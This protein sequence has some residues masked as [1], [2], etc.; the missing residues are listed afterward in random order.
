MIKTIFTMVP[1]IVVLFSLA[2]AG[3][4][5]DKDRQPPPTTFK[6]G[7]VQIDI[8][9]VVKDKQG[10]FVKG[11]RV[12]DLEVYEDDVKQDIAHLIQVD[13]P[14]AK[15]DA[16]LSAPELS[17]QNVVLPLDRRVYLAVLDDLQIGA[18]FTEATRRSVKQFV[19]RHLAPMDV[20]GIVFTS[21]VKNGIANFTADRKRL[22]AVVDTFVGR[23]EAVTA[24]RE[25]PR[26]EYAAWKATQNGYF[27]TSAPGQGMP[28]SNAMSG[29]GGQSGSAGGLG[30]AGQGQKMD[31]QTMQMMADYQ[32]DR[33]SVV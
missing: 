10:A 2:S 21:G 1:L 25:D 30:S 28:T 14:F 6:T 7:V 4:A 17:P 16:S 5:S 31:S 18:E 26:A 13:L 8:A 3:A 23:K 33:K 9:A 24:R 19:Q 22:L 12:E 27:Q 29:G 20:M 15:P 32:R 11:L